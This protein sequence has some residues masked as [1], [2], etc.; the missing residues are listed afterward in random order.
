MPTGFLP[1]DERMTAA[2]VARYLNISLSTLHHMTRLG[3][4]QARKEGKRWIYLKEQLSRYVSEGL[5]D[6][7]PQGKFEASER[8]SHSRKPCRL[9]GRVCLTASRDDTAQGSWQEGLV[10]NVSERGM[11][12]EISGTSGERAFAPLSLPA[13]ARFSVIPAG[14]KNPVPFVFPGTILRIE[15]RKSGQCFGVLLD[16]S[17]GHLLEPVP[18]ARN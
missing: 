1:D 14:R 10:L 4:I 15:S 8:R 18:T 11:L 13:Q 7:A 12:F 17:M 9:A 5:P 16:A 6:W 3:M 2:E